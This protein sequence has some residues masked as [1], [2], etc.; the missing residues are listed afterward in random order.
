MSNSTVPAPGTPGTL[1]TPLRSRGAAVTRRER[2][3]LG[4]TARL[5]SMVVTVDQQAN[6]S[7]R[8]TRPTV[9]DQPR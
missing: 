5:R 7:G 4:L 6:W 2:R 1:E 8:S 3:T 9:P